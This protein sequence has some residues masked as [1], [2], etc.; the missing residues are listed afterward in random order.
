MTREDFH[1]AAGSLKP[2]TRDRIDMAHLL[3]EA[4]LLAHMQGFNQT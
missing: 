4:H 3:Q 1:K 2:D